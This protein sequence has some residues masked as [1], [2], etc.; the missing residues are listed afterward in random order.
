MFDLMNYTWM[1]DRAYCNFKFKSYTYKIYFI[2]LV[3]PLLL[4]L[5]I[6]YLN[7]K[8]FNNSENIFNDISIV[9]YGWIVLGIIYSLYFNKYK[10]PFIQT[11]LNSKANLD[12]KHCF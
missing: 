7:L 12:I 6:S 3:F 8:I 11:L 2:C 10:A 9:L 1:G 4:L 5:L